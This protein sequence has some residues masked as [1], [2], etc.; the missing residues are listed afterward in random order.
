MTAAVI[1][2]AKLIVSLPRL[3]ANLTVA[4]NQFALLDAVGNALILTFTTTGKALSPFV[5]LRH[6]VQFF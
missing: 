5:R 2:F 4:F 6:E 3:M 1:Q